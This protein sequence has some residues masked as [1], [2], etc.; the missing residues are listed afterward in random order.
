M[1]EKKILKSKYILLRWKK[2]KS[3]FNLDPYKPIAFILKQKKS[4]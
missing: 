3:L 2:K 4:K 1:N